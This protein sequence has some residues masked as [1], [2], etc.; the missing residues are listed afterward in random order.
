MKRVLLAPLLLLCGCGASIV[1][2]DTTLDR[3]VV[4]R[5]GVAYF[6]RSAHVTRDA[7]TR[8]RTGALHPAL[9]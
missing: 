7:L 9:F 3:V 1:Q 4:Y 5:N 8:P 2:P 6:E